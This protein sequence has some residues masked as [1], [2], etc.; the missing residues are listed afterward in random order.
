[1]KVL[2][3]NAGSSSL[4]YQ[5]FDMENEK[6]IAKGNCEKIGLNQPFLKHKA[7]GKET[8]LNIAMPSHKEAIESVLKI[9]TDKEYGVIED[10]KEISAVGHRVL[11]GAEY[12]KEPVLVNAD[13]LSKLEEIIPLGPL[14]MPANIMGIKSCQAVMPNIPHVAVFDTAFHANMPDY[15][16]MYGLPYEAY[17]EWKIRRYGFH[18]SS[19]RYVANECA[20]LMNKPLKDLKIVTVHLGNGSSIAAVQDGHS[21]DT[22]MGFTPLEGL[23]MGTRCGDVDASVVGYIA[24][25][26]GWSA[27]E[28]VTYMNKKSGMLGING[29]TSDSRENDEEIK[30]GNKRAQLFV[31]MLAYRIKKY[32]G[33]YSAA[34][35]GVDAIVFTGGIGENQEDVREKAVQGLE[36]IG[37]NFDNDKNWNMPRGTVEE[38]SKPNSKVK[39]YRIPTDEELVIAR[40]TLETSKKY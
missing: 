32:I 17:T 35:G 21:V 14:H 40:D 6:V 3:I 19:H 2:V 28:V 37:V 10:L 20:K 7:N 15:A 39:V 13:V 12:Y 38:I 11:H 16:Y 24:S 5:L 9:L 31:D 33:A 36:F 8:I 34:M 27:E 25:K 22:S 1:M 30:K 26:T 4:K 29:V 23:V 18:G